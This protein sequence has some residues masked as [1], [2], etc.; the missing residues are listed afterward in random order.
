VIA[1]CRH[2]GLEELVAIIEASRLDP[3]V[4]LGQIE[5][6]LANA[7]RLA[8][9]AEQRGDTQVL[10]RARAVEMAL[11]A[12]RGEKDAAIA[13][14]DW[15]VEAARRSGAI[16]QMLCGLTSAAAAEVACG[17]LDRARALVE[18]LAQV[19]QAR[20]DT[21]YAP[22]LPALVRI[23]LAARDP[24]LATRL[25]DALDPLY[26]LHD[27][28][29]CSAR[30]ALAEAAGQHAEAAA[31]YAETADRMLRFGNRIESTYALLG[32]GRCLAGRGPPPA[33]QVRWAARE[34]FASLGYRSAL[35]E[36]DAAPRQ[37]ETVRSLDS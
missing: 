10:M 18:E 14:R 24:E 13:H 7:I 22:R 32:H 36:L 6:A 37:I 19:P 5:E 21:E 35:A 2:R 26:P 9:A 31:L 11:R 17:A 27:H 12:A 4:E 8:T 16:D 23:A 30:A 1:F 34:R 15:V 3:L 20:N 33:A 25:A 28:A 29:L